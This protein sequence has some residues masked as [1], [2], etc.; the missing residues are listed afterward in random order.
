MYSGHGI[1][2]KRSTLAAHSFSSSSERQPVPL[3]H[4][5]KSNKSCSVS[6]QAP[7]VAEV[8]IVCTII[9]VAFIFI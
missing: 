5:S 7:E 4:E 8:V 1:A 9:T 6:R 3:K 2:T